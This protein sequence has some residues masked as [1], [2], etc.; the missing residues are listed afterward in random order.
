MPAR[1]RWQPVRADVLDRNVRPPVSLEQA[2]DEG[3]EHLPVVA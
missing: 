3:L 2:A 1:I